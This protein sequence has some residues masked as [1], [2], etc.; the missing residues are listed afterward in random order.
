MALLRAVSRCGA[1]FSAGSVLLA[2]G[3][4]GCGG[5]S[6]SAL[7]SATAS[8]THTLVHTTSAFRSEFEALVKGKLVVDASG[9]VQIDT[10]SAVVTP[11]WPL[12]YSIRVTTSGFVVLDAQDAAVA[13]SGELISFAGGGEPAQPGWTNLRCAAGSVMFG[14]GAISKA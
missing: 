8:G 2:L 13:V 10:G 7:P 1:G 6:T 3:L 12:G 5:G 14:V 4:A 11:A 9:C